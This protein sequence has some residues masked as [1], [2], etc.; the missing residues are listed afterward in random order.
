MTR[1][2]A[3]Q[4]ALIAEHVRK[5]GWHC[6]SISPS[7]EGEEAFTYTIGFT[8]S[9]GAPEVLLFGMPREKAHALLAICAQRLRE[10]HT[11]VPDAED[12]ELLANGYKLVFRP[13]RADC[14]DEYLGTALR[15]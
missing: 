4:N 12:A 8:E 15:Y 10:G 14:F 2:R 3:K 1:D 9:R 5:H 11:I 7:D 13:L 6:L